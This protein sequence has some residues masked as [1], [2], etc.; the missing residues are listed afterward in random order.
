MRR[1]PRIP[2]CFLL[3]LTLTAFVALAQVE[4]A[5]IAGTITDAT[6]AVVPGAQITFTHVA[7]NTTFKM[8]ADAVGRYVS[9][10]LR[11]GGYR[12]EVESPGFKRFIR[13]GIVLQ[14]NE[15]AVLDAVMEV[16]AVTETIDVTAD[17]PLLETTQATQG[18]VIENSRIVDMPLN[19]RNYIQLA[20]LGSGTLEPLSGSRVGG[21]SSNGQ[22]TTENNYML[23]RYPRQTGRSGPS[24][25]RCYPGVQ[26]LHEQLFGRI[27]P[28]DG[29]CRER[30]DKERLERSS[31]HG[32]R[33][34]SQ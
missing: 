25:D 34:P 28:R 33:V 2:T 29:W 4:T 15:T 1:I 21:F 7:T 6:G 8:Q 19:G 27:R 17:A 31:R 12:V 9:M 14:L 18:Q 23:D 26:S 3:L 16:G 20:L 30:V 24:A 5:R 13:A 22:R 11:I 10:P 32:V